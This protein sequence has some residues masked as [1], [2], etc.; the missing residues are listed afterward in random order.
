[1]SFAPLPV[2]A[3]KP[4]YL[5]FPLLRTV[6]T[7]S[8]PRTAKLTNVGS[9]ELDVTGISVTGLNSGDFAQSNNCLPT[10]AAGATCL[11]TV[12]FTPTTQGWRTASVAIA[13]NAPGSPQTVPLTGRGTFLKW[14]P[15]QMNLGTQQV[16]T[17]STAQTVTLA[18]AGTAPIT[19]FSIEIGGV[20][21]GD[22]AQTDTCGS[23][24]NPGASC[25]VQ[26]TFTPTAVGNRLAHV[27]ITDSA[28]GGTHWVGLLGKGT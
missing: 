14:S 6:Q 22:F 7:T 27:A 2:V 19:L 18:N 28:F 4:S 20:N 15:R 10:V 16:G 26:V 24:L 5:H 17:S 8:I 21:P 23:S 1:M 12:T 13:D 25:T 11:I 3:L 9:A